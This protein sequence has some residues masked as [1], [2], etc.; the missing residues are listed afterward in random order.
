MKTIEVP[1][2][3]GEFIY[4]LS[5]NKEVIEYKVY[6]VIVIKDN[7]LIEIEGNFDLGEE[8][9]FSAK[10]IGKEIFLSEEEANEFV[11]SK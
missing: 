11:R 9:R 10:Q 1:V 7:V 6:S 4:Y 2:M 3:P 5:Y 8:V